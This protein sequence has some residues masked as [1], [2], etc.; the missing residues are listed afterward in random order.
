M[1]K[2]LGRAYMWLTSIF[3]TITIIQKPAQIPTVYG[4]YA[5]I[6]RNKLVAPSPGGPPPGL[7]TT[8]ISSLGGFPTIC[9]NARC[10]RL[11]Y[12]CIWICSPLVHPHRHHLVQAITIC[13]LEDYNSILLVSLL[14]VCIQSNLHRIYHSE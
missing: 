9:L 12:T 5:D 13:C 8:K 11:Q 2:I 7:S 1:Y 14:L 3:T 10:K 4:G 6:V